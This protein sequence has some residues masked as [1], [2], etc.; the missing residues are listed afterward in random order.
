M[1]EEVLT[2]CVTEIYTSGKLSRLY[3]IRSKVSFFSVD[4]V[5]RICNIKH[6]TSHVLK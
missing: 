2:L 6:R 5:M 3:V 4:S 1:P